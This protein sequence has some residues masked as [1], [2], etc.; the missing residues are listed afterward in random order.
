MIGIQY[1]EPL[2]RP[3]AEAYSLIFQVTLGCSWNRCAYCEMYTTKQFRPRKESEVLAEI[4]QAGEMYRD[5]RKIFLADG[6]AMVL[7]TK[8]LLR[9]LEVIK[10]SFP[11]V[12]RV[13][14]YAMPGDISSKSIDQL[15]ALYEAGL[16][17]VYVGVESGDDDV[18][19][20]VAKSETAASTLEGLQ[21]AHEVGIKSSVMIVNGLAGRKYSE[22]HAINSAKLLNRIQPL[23]FSTLILTL[24]YGEDRYRERFKGD[25]VAMGVPELLNEM[26][27]LIANTELDR[28]IFRSNHASNFLPLKGTLSRDK[29]KLLSIIRDV[30]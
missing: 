25:Y 14:T 23:Y 19:D 11:G 16:Q 6:N 10:E 20:M 22:Q 5:V 18:L 8:R 29:A 9:I 26:G 1:D 17:L 3:P 30:R 15:K 7:S 21:K 28:T 12:G 27:L 24:P 13:S 2:F 4:R